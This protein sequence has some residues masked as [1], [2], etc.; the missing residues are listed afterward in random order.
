MSSTLAGISIEFRLKKP[1]NS[2][3]LIHVTPSRID[4]VVIFLRGI[5]L[6][7]CMPVIVSEVEIPTC[8]KFVQSSNALSSILV[9]LSGMMTDVRFEHPLNLLLVDYQYYTL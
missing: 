8:L 1:L 7:T 9:T 4:I 2:Y 5:K 6:V 3:P